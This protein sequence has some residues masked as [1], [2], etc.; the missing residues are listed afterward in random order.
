MCVRVCA[1]TDM[2]KNEFITISRDVILPEIT[3]TYTHPH[4]S[5]VTCPEIAINVS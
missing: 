2:Y 3:Y 1:H 5:S 4:V